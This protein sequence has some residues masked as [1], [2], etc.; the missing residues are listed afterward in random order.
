MGA[1]AYAARTRQ[2]AERA[3]LSLDGPPAALGTL[4]PAERAV[5]ALVCEGLSNREIAERMVLSR[6]TIEFHLT[7]VFR[8]LDVPTRAD[9]RRVVADGT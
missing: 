1:A 3:G 2:A 7:N 6:K 9:L 8:R 4:T 5:V